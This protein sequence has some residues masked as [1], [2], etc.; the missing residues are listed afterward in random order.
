VIPANIALGRQPHSP[1]RVGAA[2]QHRMSAEAPAPLILPRPG[3]LTKPSLVR[4]DVLPTCTIAGLLNHLRAWAQAF[5]GFDVGEDD[6]LLLN[7]YAAIYGCAPTVE[8]IAATDGLVLMDVLEYVQTHG[9]RIDSQNVVELTFTSIDVTDMDAVRDAIDK[10][11]GAYLGVTLYQA[12]VVPGLTA[13][14]GGIGNAGPAVGGHCIVPKGYQQQTADT[15]TW[16]IL[17]PADDDWY[18]PRLDEAFDIRWIM[19]TA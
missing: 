2:P 10:S 5:H 19:A 17:I 15:A 8:A 7:L 13:W 16:G 3:V 12:D 18:L 14:T 4:N 6:Q 1:Q 9:F 11:G